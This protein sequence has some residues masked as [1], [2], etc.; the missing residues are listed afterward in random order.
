MKILKWIPM[1]IGVVIIFIG[2]S[3]FLIGDFFVEMAQ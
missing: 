3:I 1:A 2:L